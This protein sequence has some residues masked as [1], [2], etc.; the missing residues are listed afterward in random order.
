MYIKPS[1]RIRNEFNLISGLAKESREPIYIT[2]NGEGDGVYMNLEA[3]E[4]RELLMKFK[5]EMELARRCKLAGLPTYSSDD[6]LK[7]AEEIMAE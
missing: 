4:E 2:I 6:M 3:F 1:T 7:M 5:L